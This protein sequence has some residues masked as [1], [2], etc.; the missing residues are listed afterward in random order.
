MNNLYLHTVRST[1]DKD[2]REMIPLLLNQEDNIPENFYTSFMTALSKWSQVFNQPFQ[3]KPP[4]DLLIRNNVFMNDLKRQAC[5]KPVT[6]LLINTQVINNKQI[7]TFLDQLLRLQIPGFEYIAIYNPSRHTSSSYPKKKLL[8][9]NYDEERQ[10]Y[11]KHQ[12]ALTKEQFTQ[13]RKLTNGWFS[14][15]KTIPE[16][17]SRYNIVSFNSLRYYLSQWLEQVHFKT[18]MR[19]EIDCLVYLSLLENFSLDVIKLVYNWYGVDDQLFITDSPIIRYDFTSKSYRFA[20]DVIPLLKEKQILIS[21]KQKQKFCLF[22]ADWYKDHEDICHAIPLYRQ[23]CAHV[24]IVELL[25]K[26]TFPCSRE[27]ANLCINTINEMP[28]FLIEKYPIVQIVNAHMLCTLYRY[29]DARMLMEKFCEHY[30]KFDQ[31]SEAIKPILGEAYV[32]LVNVCFFS[33]GSIPAHL[34][35]QLLKRSNELIP[36]GSKLLPQNI[37]LFSDTPVLKLIDTQEGSLNGFVQNLN[38]LEPYIIT[39][40]GG[41]WAGCSYL[42]EAERNYYIRNF[43]EVESNAGKAITEA[44]K[45]NQ[46]DIACSAAFLLMR[47][48]AAKGN[49]KIMMESFDLLKLYAAEADYQYFFSM[50]D[51]AESWLNLQLG[52]KHNIAYWI[53]DMSV[54]LKTMMP[55]NYGRDRILHAKYL[56]I[57]EEYEELLSFSEETI[58]LFKMRKYHLLNVYLYM[59]QAVTYYKIGDKEKGFAVFEEVYRWSHKNDLLMPIIELG[60]AAK[61]LA[62][63]YQQSSRTLIPEEWLSTIATKAHSYSTYLASIKKQ[64]LQKNR[65][66]HSVLIHLTSKELTILFLIYQGRTM[67]EIAQLQNKSY[68]T[69]R[70]VLKRIYNKL[71]IS[72][73]TEAIR[74]A[75]E[76]HIEKY[77]E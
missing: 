24:E 23:I 53:Q 54:N 60:N 57:N 19:K 29:N 42:A 36:E 43:K 17:H 22:V 59:I 37:N 30:D 15:V 68:E 56:L 10:Y 27:V 12:L 14:A 16:I 8:Y 72:N 21:N 71:N 69:I 41:N 66:K 7:L 33:D 40:T 55:W 26:I 64:F 28:A 1:L 46:S 67:K 38:Q 65:E 52:K 34:V 45:Y 9:L 11:I 76:N 5:Q 74:L 32:L 6:L 13:I 77:F 62:V 61:L 35:S 63:N 44:L 18:Y 4:S 20:E 49:Y 48:N 31:T 58:H 47:Y 73:R 51:L 39:A 25:K 75:S 50:P 2:N 70:G 3:Q